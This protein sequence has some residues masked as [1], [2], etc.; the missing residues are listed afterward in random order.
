MIILSF[1][2]PLFANTFHMQWHR[3]WCLH[4]FCIFQSILGLNC[5]LQISQGWLCLLPLSLY[6]SYV[7]I[8]LDFSKNFQI[9]AFFVTSE[10]SI[11]EYVMF[12][13][14]WDCHFCRFW[15]A[16]PKCIFCVTVT[17]DITNLGLLLLHNYNFGFLDLILSYLRQS[18][19]LYLLVW[20]YSLSHLI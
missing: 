5:I 12:E 8:I 2:S 9:F 7:M 10:K 11:C 1:Y 3:H 13:F 20:K 18:V 17:C 14:V 16:Q 6:G 4:I 15:M 19:Y